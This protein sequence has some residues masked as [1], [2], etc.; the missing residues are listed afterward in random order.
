MSASAPKNS[1][2]TSSDGWVLLV[3]NK[4]DEIAGGAPLEE[5]V[6]LKRAKAAWNG[7]VDGL[8]PTRIGRTS[9]S[10]FQTITSILLSDT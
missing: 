2:P 6:V 4:D 5:W 7:R 8:N 1:T 3:E 10:L 9:G